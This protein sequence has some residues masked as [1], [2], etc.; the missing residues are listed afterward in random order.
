MTQL[1][2]TLLC[3][4]PATWSLTT[5]N[6]KLFK[7]DHCKELGFHAHNAGWMRLVPPAPLMASR[8]ASY[9]NANV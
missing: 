3:G 7:C 8:I 5:E 2:N 4:N 1:C 9:Y 6:G